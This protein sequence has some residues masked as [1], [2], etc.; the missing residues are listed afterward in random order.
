M[1]DNQLPAETQ[2]PADTQLPVGTTL[3][4]VKAPW[5][6][7]VAVL[8]ALMIVVFCWIEPDA[9]ER[10]RFGL[11]VLIAASGFL[12]FIYYFL[13]TRERNKGIP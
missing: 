4:T 5:F 11:Q 1:A 6:Q 10:I 8:A 9:T 2:P 3:H 13:V 7:I 12:V